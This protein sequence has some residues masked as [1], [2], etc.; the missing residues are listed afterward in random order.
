MFA[1]APTSPGRLALFLLLL[2]LGACSNAR[3][4]AERVAAAQGLR[5]V[6]VRTDA[7][8]LSAFVRRQA[9]D[10]PLVVYIEGDGRA[11]INSSTPSADPT[12]RSPVALWLAARDASP[13]VAYVARPCQYAAREADPACATP[14]YWTGHRFAEEVV[15]STSQAIDSLKAGGQG[16][17]HLVG[18]SGGG[19]IAALVAARRIDVLSLRT[20]AGNLDHEAFTRLHKVSAMNNSLNAADVAPG[21]AGLP[22]LHLVGGKDEIVPRIVAES[23]LRRMGGSPCARVV[24]VP[25]VEHLGPW[26]AAWAKAGVPTC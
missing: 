24:E 8:V 21:L 5:P 14:R 20:V 1:F 9:T 7:F 11:W 19:A 17:V 2:A 16:G 3:V 15:A 25:G 13:N 26:E 23:Y 10:L 12:P 18:F 6:Q 4:D 22:Q